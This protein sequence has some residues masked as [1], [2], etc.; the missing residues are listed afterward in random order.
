MGLLARSRLHDGVD[1]HRAQRAPLHVEVADASQPRLVARSALS[2]A[3]RRALA[4]AA[5]M[6]VRERWP[7]L[8]EDAHALAEAE[9]GAA[10]PDGAAEA[11]GP[12]L[13][14]ESELIADN[15]CGGFTPD[16]G[17]YVIRLDLEPDGT[18][19]LPP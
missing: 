6:V 7:R 2:P 19:R 4:A 12:A 16:G 18:P 15:G 10:S 17:E 3:R 1:R 8:E 5:A 11:G 14:P 13:E 9:A